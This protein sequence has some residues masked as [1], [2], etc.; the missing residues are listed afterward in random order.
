MKWFKKDKY[1]CCCHYQSYSYQGVKYNLYNVLLSAVWVYYLFY[2]VFWSRLKIGD[3]NSTEMHMVNCIKHTVKDWKLKVHIINKV[4][5]CHWRAG[6]KRTLA[7]DTGKQLD[8]L[9]R[10]IFLTCTSLKLEL[11]HIARL[12]KLWVTFIS[13]LTSIHTVY[14]GLKC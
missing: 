11:N 12:K 7:R 3:L 14:I 9:L 2:W 13:F 1:A 10:C 5:T 4:L 6:V 8:Y